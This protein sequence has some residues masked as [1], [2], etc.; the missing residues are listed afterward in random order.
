MI[1][2]LLVETRTKRIQAFHPYCLYPWKIGWLFVLK[3]NLNC[4]VMN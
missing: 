3:L 1:F 2:S 4:W